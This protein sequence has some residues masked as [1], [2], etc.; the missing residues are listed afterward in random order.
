MFLLE[1][2]RR[3]STVVFLGGQLALCHLLNDVEP[4]AEVQNELNVGGHYGEG[5]EPQG[6]AE[7]KATS[8]P[9]CSH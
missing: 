5:G 3:T 8:I 2:F 6:R 4:A 9:V 1:G 7:I